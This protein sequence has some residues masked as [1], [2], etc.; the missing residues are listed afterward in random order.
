MKTV[1]FLQDFDGAILKNNKE[2]DVLE[3]SDIHANALKTR[4]IAEIIEGKKEL[5][6][7]HQTKEEKFL[8]QPLATKPKKK[9][10]TK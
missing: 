1:K 5:K 6:E 2:G 7:S 9:L 8:E 4:G 10:K 3:V